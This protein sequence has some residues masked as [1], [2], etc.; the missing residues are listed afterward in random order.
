MICRKRTGR[1][2]TNSR[3]SCLSRVNDD[4]V[5][6][7]LTP[8]GRRPRAVAHSSDPPMTRLARRF[9]VPIR[10]LS[11]VPA[12]H[13]TPSVTRSFRG[14]PLSRRCRT[15]RR[16]PAF[17]WALN[18]ERPLPLGVRHPLAAI[19]CFAV[20]DRSV[21][22]TGQDANDRV[23]RELR[24]RCLIT[25]VRRSALLP[26]YEQIGLRPSAELVRRSGP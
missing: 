8:I 18:P 14:D 7:P 10:H 21:R 26:A 16:P 25:E 20:V 9:I 13:L 5:I 11:H 15:W 19:P 2:R 6:P 22:R 17:G 3:G 1:G 4:C 12:S 24:S 23:F